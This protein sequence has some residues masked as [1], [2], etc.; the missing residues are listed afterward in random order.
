ML[1]LHP[2][3]WIPSRAKRAVKEKVVK[4]RRSLSIKIK[5]FSAVCARRRA[6]AKAFAGTPRRMA[7]LVNLQSTKGKKGGKGKAGKGKG[8]VHS[9]EGEGEEE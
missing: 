9:F 6:T 3:I 5:M 4:A 8:K 7:V 1:A 2:W